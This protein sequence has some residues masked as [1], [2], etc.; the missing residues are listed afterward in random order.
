MEN[1]KTGGLTFIYYLLEWTPR[2]RHLI[3]VRKELTDHDTWGRSVPSDMGRQQ[4]WWQTSL[5]MGA[6]M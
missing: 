5:E 4:G 1:V 3:Y 2:L 6:F